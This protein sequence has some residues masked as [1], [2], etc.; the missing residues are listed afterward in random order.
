M[1]VGCSLSI[2]GQCFLKCTVETLTIRVDVDSGE[3]EPFPSFIRSESLVG[4]MPPTISQCTLETFSMGQDYV[5]N[6]WCFGLL[7]WLRG[8]EPA[9]QCR[10]PEFHPQVGKILWRRKWQP[11]LVFLPEEA[12]GQRSLAGYSPELQGVGH[13]LVTYARVMVC[14]SRN[15]FSNLKEKERGRVRVRGHHSRY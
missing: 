13:S 12:H 4:D 1:K 9:C 7:K 3:D 8:K 15:V 5:F 2:L 6:M 14:W 11:T 10:R